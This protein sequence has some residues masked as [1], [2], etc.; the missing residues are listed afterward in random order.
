V[1]AVPRWR[2]STARAFTILDRQKNYLTAWRSKLRIAQVL[3]RERVVAERVIRFGNSFESVLGSRRQEFKAL[4]ARL[5]A[6]GVSQV[7]L[8]GSGS[9]VFGILPRGAKARALVAHFEGAEALYFARSAR[10]GLS[11][12]A[13]S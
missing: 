1:I 5:R 3:G 7:R 6:V 11:L 8:T 9:A 10:R 13:R 4:C 12:I 2:V